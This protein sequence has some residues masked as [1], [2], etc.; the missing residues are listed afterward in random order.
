LLKHITVVGLHAYDGHLRDP[1]IKVRKAQC[2]EGYGQVVTLQQ[3]IEKKYGKHLVIIAGGT[4]SYAIHSQRSEIECSPGTYIY[5]DKNY[6][7]TL[8]EQHYLHAALVVTRVVS[9]PSP[10]TLCVDLGHKA[11]ASE[12]PLD[13]RVFFL[14]APDLKPTGHSEEH[15]VFAIPEGARYEVGDILYGVPFHVCPTVALHDQPAIIE[16]HQ[17][18]TYW[19]TIA[20]NRKITV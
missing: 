5:W 16:D 15:M 9:M 1:D 3:A 20:R 2:D 8:P 11:I 10:G 14:N 19:Q 7:Q 4:P 13:K 12:N 6:E 18:K 17:V